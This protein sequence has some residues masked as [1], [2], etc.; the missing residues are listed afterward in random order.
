MIMT[1]HDQGL[2]LGNS[3]CK[4]GTPQSTAGCTKDSSL[5]SGVLE[6]VRLD[7]SEVRCYLVNKSYFK[8]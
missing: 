1:Q 6:A 7:N 3:A 4:C 5:I 2:C 8:E